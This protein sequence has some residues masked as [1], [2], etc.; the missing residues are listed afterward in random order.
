MHFA[1]HQG[2]DLALPLGQYA[3][4]FQAEVY[5][6]LACVRSDVF[7]NV[8]DRRINICSDSQA[9]LKA[10]QSPRFT[11]VLV[12]ECFQAVQSLAEKNQVWLLWIPGHSGLDGN[13]L[14][15]QLAKQGSTTQFIGPEP[16]L[17][18][19]VQAAKLALR[20]WTRHKQAGEW[21][22]NPKCRQAKQL[23]PGPNP[24]SARNLLA[25]TRHQVRLVVGV[26]TGHC[27]L[28]RHLSI[29]RLVPTPTCPLCQEE[30]ETALHFLGRCAALTA[31]RLRILGA[32]FLE[33][34]AIQLLNLSDIL[35]FIRETGRFEPQQ[36]QQD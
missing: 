23:I 28:Q 33:H 29:M 8:T 16:A 4:V 11:S 10:L 32:G 30:E 21:R 12:E 19:S 20:R 3:T 1:D 36:V 17:G 5:A 22:G 18:V 13:E 6:L 9:T 7:S 27:T 2:E 15:D 25:L 35:R 24:R 31:K 26:L 34:T 14:S